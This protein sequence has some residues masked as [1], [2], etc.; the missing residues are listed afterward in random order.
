MPP[1]EAK[2][3][4]SAG[5]SAGSASSAGRRSPVGADKHLADDVP[6]DPEPPRRPRSVT[7]LDDIHGELD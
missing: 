6:I 7:D 3:A 1:T 2:P 5:S 4:S